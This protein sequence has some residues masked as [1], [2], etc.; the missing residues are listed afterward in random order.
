MDKAN[1]NTGFP[2][3]KLAEF[4]ARRTVF[5]KNALTEIRKVHAAYLDYCTPGTETLSMARFCRRVAEIY[6]RHV[7]VEISRP[8]GRP[9]RCFSGLKLKTPG[10][11]N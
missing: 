8:N 3:K 11:P 2:M 1:L 6:G 9:V 7:S 5:D 10:G 4:I